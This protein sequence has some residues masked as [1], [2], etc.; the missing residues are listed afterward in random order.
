MRAKNQEAIAH[1]AWL[2]FIS[3]LL[4]AGVATADRGTL[5]H[6]DLPAGVDIELKA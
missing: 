6:L 1:R 4:V 5:M 3:A 2:T